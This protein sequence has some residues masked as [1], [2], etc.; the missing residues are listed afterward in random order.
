MGPAA[1][2]QHQAEDL[3]HTA[4]Q[5]QDCPETTSNVI[6]LIIEIYVFG[7]VIGDAKYAPY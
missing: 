6:I 5:G 1:G 4:Q 2:G 7:R 3:P